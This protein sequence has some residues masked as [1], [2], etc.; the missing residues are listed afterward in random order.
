MSYFV[1]AYD[2]VDRF[3]ERRAQYRD[4]HLRLVRDRH[5]RG[6]V[7]MGGALGDPPDGAML[8]FKGDSPH[9][10]EEFAR[11]DPYVTNGLVTKW[12]IRPWNVVVGP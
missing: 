3:V 6:E 7:I 1:L 2:V 12:Q 9:V 5:T 11:A 8:I 4:E 10:A